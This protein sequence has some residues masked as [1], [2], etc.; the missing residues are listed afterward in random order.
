MDV[1]TFREF[2]ASAFGQRV[3]TSL[4]ARLARFAPRR[5]DQR[6]MGLGFAPPY[7]PLFETED[8][9]TLAFMQARQGVTR[10]PNAE[11]SKAAL[12]DECELPLLESVIDVAL[13]VHGLELSEAP[14]EML[15]EIWRVLA[16]QGKLLLVVPNRRGLWS[17]SDATPFGDGR[18]FSRGQI[19]NLL[20]EA[21]FTVTRWDS[22]LHFLPSSQSWAVTAAPVM[23]AI[24]RK[25]ATRL[26]GVII[27]EAEKQVYAFTSGKRARRLVSRLR[28]VLLPTAQPVPNTGQ[29]G[30]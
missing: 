15:H 17:A 26:A 16:P 1:V 3:A 13:V 21:R 25:L 27:V 28:P 11:P 2:Y 22:G 23:E 5:K 24:G 8:A 29:T 10:W 20:K 18:P 6:V 4:S 7:L 30:L 14:L 12:V 19:A 9:T